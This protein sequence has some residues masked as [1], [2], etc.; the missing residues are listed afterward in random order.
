M[1]G[2]L[3]VQRPSPTTVSFTV[4]NAP[5]RSNTPAKLL[6]GLQILFRT[7][8]FCAVVL[9]AIAR[10]RHILFDIDGHLIQWRNVW[11]NPLALRICHLADSY[12][13]W[14]IMVVSAVVV[15]GVFRRGYTGMDDSPS[16]LVAHV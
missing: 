15:Y 1:P 9:I 5:R 11:A 8:L 7:I 12:N 2:R 13:P 16:Y 4:S 14:V 6:W 3:T 10:S